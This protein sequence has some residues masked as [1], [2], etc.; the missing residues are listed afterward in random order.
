[1]SDASDNKSLKLAIGDLVRWREP[2]GGPPFFIQGEDT[3]TMNSS[4]LGI[5]YDITYDGTSSILSYMVRW[6]NGVI[7]PVFIN[8]IA[9]VAKGGE[10]VR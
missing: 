4:Y 6:S 5:I 8:E 2:M 10:D 3:F 1:M 7:F 9:L